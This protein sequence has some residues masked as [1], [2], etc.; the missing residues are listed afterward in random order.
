MG[1]PATAVAAG[2]QLP[3]T[4][5]PEEQ[6]PA[7]AATSNSSSTA[8]AMTTDASLVAAPGTMPR[9]VPETS[10]GRVRMQIRTK[11]RGRR[12]K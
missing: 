4:P 1:D 12:C 8:R 7:T 6:Q 2:T 5:N 9:I 11:A 3:S 10:R